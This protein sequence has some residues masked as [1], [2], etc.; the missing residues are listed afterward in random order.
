MLR[1]YLRCVKY[2]EDIASGTCTRISI[3]LDVRSCIFYFW[4][5][6]F[7]HTYSSSVFQVV[8]YSVVNIVYEYNTFLVVYYSFVGLVVTN[9]S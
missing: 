6:L 3:D 2:T 5:L 4:D 1:R 8:L 7:R 9:F